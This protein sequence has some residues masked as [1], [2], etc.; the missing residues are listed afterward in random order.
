MKAARILRFGPP[1]VIAEDDLP[2]PKPAPEQ[3]QVR[4]KAAG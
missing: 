2:Q 4:V 3:L 1:S